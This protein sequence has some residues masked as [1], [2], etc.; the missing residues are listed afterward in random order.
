MIDTVKFRQY[1]GKLS[2]WKAC[3]PD[4][5]YGFW[6]EEFTNIHEKIIAYLNKSLENGRIPEWMAIRRT[7]LILK[8]K[9]KGNET[10]N[11]RP[12]TCLPIM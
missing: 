6:I 4:E 3:R 10:S 2:K 9:K 12:V 7:C 8:G 11:S 1:L 5:I